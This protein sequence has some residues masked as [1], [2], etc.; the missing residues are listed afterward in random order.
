MKRV[1]I[2]DIEEVICDCCGKIINEE[3]K[4]DG[5]CDECYDALNEEDLINKIEACNFE[6]KFDN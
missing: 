4:S 5:L 3:D 1:S 2:Y 6:I